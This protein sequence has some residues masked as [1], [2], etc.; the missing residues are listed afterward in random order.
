M[1]AIDKFNRVA[2]DLEASGRSAFIITP[3]PGELPVVTKAIRAGAD[4]TITLQAV[5]DSASI[6]HPCYAGEIISLRLRYVTAANPPNMV[7]VGY[8]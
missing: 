7:I 1:P 3:G 4:G 2:D 5:D 8:A 6:P